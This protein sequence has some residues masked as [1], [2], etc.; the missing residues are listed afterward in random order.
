MKQAEDE[1][2]IKSHFISERVLE[3]I[4]RNGKVEVS[5]AGQGV[6]ALVVELREE[7]A[8]HTGSS[9]A[10]DLRDLLERAAATLAAHTQE[11]RG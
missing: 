5:E 10:D 11:G 9:Y 4:E 8:R 3:V 2:G 6:D 7:A 1:S